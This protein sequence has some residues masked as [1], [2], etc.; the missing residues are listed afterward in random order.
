MQERF[1][2]LGDSQYMALIALEISRRCKHQ[3]DSIDYDVKCPHLEMK[4]SLKILL[5]TNRSSVCEFL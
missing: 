5:I 3:R 4:P 2:G 1:G